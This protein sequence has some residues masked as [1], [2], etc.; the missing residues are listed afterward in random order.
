M[1]AEDRVLTAALL[2]AL[3]LALVGGWDGQSWSAAASA[4]MLTPLLLLIALVMHHLNVRERGHGRS[5][6]TLPARRLHRAVAAEALGNG[7]LTDIDPRLFLRPENS[8]GDDAIVLILKN[9]GAQIWGV[10]LYWHHRKRTH[11]IDQ[12]HPTLLRG[13]EIIAFVQRAALPRE[14]DVI[15]SYTRRDGREQEECWSLS[16]E[17]GAFD[18]VYGGKV[19]GGVLPVHS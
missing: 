2:I 8:L 18:C 17:D 4:T 7:P 10:S 5:A 19:T 3:I 9:Y 6:E 16:I 1:S 13:E 12:T 11:F 14:F 15:V